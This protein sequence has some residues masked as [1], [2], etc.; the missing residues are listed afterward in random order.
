MPDPLNL[1]V[2]T[3]VGG[4]Q[5]AMT[6]A[7]A[8]R[9]QIAQ[10]VNDVRETTP[11]AQSFTNFVTMNLV[12]NAQLAAGGTA[13]MSFLPDDVIDTAEIAG[14][15]YINVGTLLPFF[16][17][18]LPEIAY[19]LHK[20]G[21][22]WVLDPV[23]AGI[24]KTR[25]AILESFRTYPPTIVRGNASEI[26]A[27]DAMW[28][29]AQHDSTVPGTRPAGVEAVDEVDSAVDAAKRVA[30]HLAKYSPVGAGAVAV[31]GAVDLVT[32]G[33]RVFRLPGGSA[34]MTKITGA[35]CSLGGVTATYLAVAEPLVAAI[36]A[37]LLYNR[38]SEIAEAKRPVPDL[39]KWRCLTRFGTSPRKSP[40]PK[41][42]STL[43]NPCMV[44]GISCRVRQ[45]RM[46]KIWTIAGSHCRFSESLT[47]KG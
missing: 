11:L 32:D 6:H 34:M 44:F 40:L 12:A 33:E 8:L 42:S 41:S 24:G 28:G 39:S 31:S 20:N 45:L 21:K 5:W 29:L 36:S 17:D 9:E 25:T 35:G 19:K 47:E 22:T 23:A 30:R 26:I 14:S 15:N 1:L 2:R 37:S 43:P 13:A 4:R 7:A 38:A 18:A 27:L 3:N 46:W 10:A 16:K